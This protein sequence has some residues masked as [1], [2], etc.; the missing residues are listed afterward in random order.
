MPETQTL[1]QALLSRPWAI[2]GRANLWRF[3]KNEAD[4]LAALA[5]GD[6]LQRD[7]I[8]NLQYANLSA[9]NKL[10]GLGLIESY[11]DLSR[12]KHWQLTRQG[13]CLIHA[14]RKESETQAT[15]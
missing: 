6:A 5:D 15:R 4:A 3:S 9:L 14:V 1:F 7:M 13:H 10:S 8:G 12:Q 2:Y 11:R